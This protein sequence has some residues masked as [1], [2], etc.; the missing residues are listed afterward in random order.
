LAGARPRLGAGSEVVIVDAATRAVR[1]VATGATR[2]VTPAWRPDGRAIVAAVDDDQAFTLWE[3]LLEGDLARRA[4]TARESLWPDVSADGSTIVFVGY[5]DKGFDLFTMPYPPA[6]TDTFVATHMPSAQALHSTESDAS[7]APLSSRRDDT[8]GP[9]RPWST[10]A[11]TSWTPV[12]QSDANQ[13]RLGVAMGGFDILGYHAY[14]A[15]ATW[16]LSGPDAFGGPAR[17]APDWDVSYAYDRWR[18]RLFI[19]LSRTT[20]FFRSTASDDLRSATLHD[21]EMEA[22]VVLPFN[23]VRT[24]NQLFASV[25]KGTATYADRDSRESQRRVAARAGWS[26]R[27]ARSYGYSISP[28]H[29]VAMGATAEAS[30][31]GSGGPGDTTTLTADLRTYLPGVLPRHV[32]ALRSAVGV[33]AGARDLSRLFRLGGGAGNVETLDFGRRAF[34]L[35]RGFASDSFAGTRV[36]VVN[37]EYRSPL[38]RIQRGIGTWPIFLHTVHG[39]LFAD[40]GHAWTGPFRKDDVKIALGA[41]LSANVVAGYW[42]PLTLTVGAGWGHDGSGRIADGVVS[43]VRVGRAF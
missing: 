20:S 9:Y 13:F 28:E 19:S 40:A 31:F 32:V 39:A 12:Y 22:G 42:L 5:T 26:M 27:T 33:S 35:L 29:G 3:F 30:G 2:A 18:P 36:A 41:E 17:R 10:L 38:A 24:A 11:P 37:L 15:S 1:V 43:Y 16:R 23:R 21:D 7:P 34:S 4:L 8:D 6:R 14:A 25:L